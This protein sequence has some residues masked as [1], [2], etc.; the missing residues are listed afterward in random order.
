MGAPNPI[1]SVPVQPPPKSPFDFSGQQAP[2]PQQV[3]QSVQQQGVSPAPRTLQEFLNLLL[4]Q[5]T[6]KK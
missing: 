4:D 5:Q 6:P 2:T 1:A 3:S